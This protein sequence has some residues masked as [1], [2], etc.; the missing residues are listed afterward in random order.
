[1]EIIFHAHH[2]SISPR[3]QQRAEQCIRKL[4]QRWG[5]AVDAIVRFEEDGPTRRVEILLHAARGRRL[6]AR[7]E[8]RS[9]GPALSTALDRL[10]ARVSHVK[11]TRKAVAR[12]KAG[13]IAPR[14]L[15]RA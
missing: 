10:D 8:G 11:R 6:V 2:A 3:L 14:R 9:F 12:V 15:A 7:G 4:V 1:M 5:R 13:R